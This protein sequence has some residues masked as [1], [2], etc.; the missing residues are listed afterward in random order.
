MRFENRRYLILTA[1]QAQGVN[2]N[3]V[4]ESSLEGLRYSTD[5]TKTF[6]KYTIEVVEEDITYTIFNPESE[7]EDTVTKAAGT[8]GRPSI[9]EESMI[10]YNHAQ[11]LEI[12]NTEEWTGPLEP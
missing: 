10:E 4:E 2:F 8:Y 12:L 9:Y 5:E 11:I 3:Q 6:V 7:Q 1:E